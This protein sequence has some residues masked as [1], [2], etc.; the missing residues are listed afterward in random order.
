MAT[1]NI[2]NHKHLTLADGEISEQNIRTLAL[3]PVHEVG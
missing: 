3:L 2:G 1:N